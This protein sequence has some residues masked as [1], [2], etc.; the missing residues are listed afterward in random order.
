MAMK[1]IPNEN[2]LLKKIKSQHKK[3]SL[4]SILTKESCKLLKNKSQRSK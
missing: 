3:L 4:H 2:H 1:K